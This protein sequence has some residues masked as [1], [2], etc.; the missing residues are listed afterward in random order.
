MRKKKICACNKKN[1]FKPGHS[2]RHYLEADKAEEAEADASQ[3][4]P[5]VTSAGPD[6]PPSPPHTR[7][8][9]RSEKERKHKGQ[10][11]FIAHKENVEVLFNTAFRQHLK[12]SPNCN[13]DLSLKQEKKTKRRTIS[14]AWS[15][16]CK[17]CL[18]ESKTQKF[19]RE[20]SKPGQGRGRKQSSLNKALGFA[21][22]NSPI[23]VTGFRKL[24]ITLGI[25]PGST[26]GVQ[27]CINRANE[28]AC[29]LKERTL[30]EQR[31]RLKSG[32]PVTVEGDSRY[33]NQIG[34]SSTPMQYGSQFVCTVIENMTKEGKILGISYGSKL[35]RDGTRKVRKGEMPLCPNHDGCT[36]T[37]G[38]MESIG[39]EDIQAEEAVRP[40]KEAGIEVT[41]ITTDGDSKFTTGVKKHFPNVTCLKDSIHY[42]RTQETAIK[43]AKFSK[44]MFQGSRADVRNQKQ[45]WFAR[46]IK[47]RCSAEFT[48]A[49]YLSRKIKDKQKRQ[50]KMNELLKETPNAIMMCIQGD[51]SFCA[52]YSLVCSGT[53][54]KNFMK[55]LDLKETVT[56]NAADKKVLL[57]ILLKRLGPGAVS[58]TYRL[59]T[60]Q[61]AEA[62]NRKLLSVMPK[63]TTFMRTYRGRTC[64][65]MLDHNF[66]FRK[67]LS[68]VLDKAGHSVSEGVHTDIENIH[69]QI[70]YRKAYQQREAF[71]RN[72]AKKRA[73]LF[74]LY[75][76][77]KHKPVTYKK[78][79]TIFQK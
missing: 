49:Y 37:M 26:R 47:R 46:D 30:A 73:G 61:R 39:Q 42:A 67:M 15:M 63:Q 69:K 40:L 33:N 20:I 59:T 8:Y 68:V 65:A 2:I 70:L 27:L 44:G 19:Y 36:A 71:K 31:E 56:L 5:P 24:M 11:Y 54:E 12:Q 6:S 13:G 57:P 38:Q 18:Y 52:K 72:R 1:G 64:M 23:G 3:C 7:G 34:S 78:N 60:T 35:C 74:S 66:G 58:L 16:V 45:K 32:K 50:T 41:E 17:S 21:L 55:K 51:C 76:K 4:L 29:E 28:E 53:K 25:E 75:R 9:T 14:S 43:S 22:I 48:K 77:L 10:E 62:F 79:S